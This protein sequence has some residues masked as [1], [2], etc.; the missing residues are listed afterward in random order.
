MSCM[1]RVLM[2][3][4][5]IVAGPAA[6][7]RTIS[8]GVTQA[9]LDRERTRQWHV[10]YGSRVQYVLD[11]QAMKEI[12][13]E[14]TCDVCDITVRYQRGLADQAQCVADE[15]A[16][17]LA[18]VQETTG[19]TILTRSTIY[20]LRFDDTP[21]DFDIRLAVEPNEFPLPL[22]VRADDES[23]ESILTQ[24]RSYPYLF[25]HEL[26]ETSVAAARRDGVVLP[27]LSWGP[28]GLV[29]VNNYTRWFR[30]GLA[31]YSGYVAYE[32]LSSD[33][34]MPYQQSLLHADPFSSLAQ[35]GDRLFSWRQSSPTSYDRAYYNAAL[36]L[37]LLIE[38]RHGGEAIHEIVA[39]IGRHKAVDGPDLVK[40]VNR[41]IGADIR[42]LAKDFQ[43]PEIGAELERLTPA[44]VLNSGLKVQEGLFVH[45]VEKDGLAAEAGLQE[46]DTITAVGATPVANPL[47]FEQALFKVR[48]QSS[49]TLTVERREAGTLTLELPLEQPDASGGAPQPAG[50]R[51]HPWG[52]DRMET[53]ISPSS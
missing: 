14:G 16:E 36:G 28:W 34:P 44:L 27:D 53:T 10:H 49:V 4:A 22:F 32:V 24:N 2:L 40:I 35:V 47:D 41:V 50:R 39:E 29:H 43:F 38:E 31:N 9:V 33:I 30:E 1:V 46:K 3:A 45:E 17:L 11:D 19:V 8:K 37:L 25:A 20:L 6:G 26:V 5:M 23:C 48:E 7:C 52:E 15:T 13:F 21:L 12:E 51:H 18:R 42:R